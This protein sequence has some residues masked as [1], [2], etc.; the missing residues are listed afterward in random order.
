MFETCCEYQLQ[1]EVIAKEQALEEY[2]R[3]CNQLQNEMKLLVWENKKLNEKLDPKPVCKKEFGQKM[4]T[5]LL[6][7]LENQV[8]CL[9]KDLELVQAARKEADV[10]RCRLKEAAISMKARPVTSPLPQNA[11]K[12]NEKMLQLKEQYSRVR[13]DYKTK[14]SQVAALQVENQNLLLE[15]DEKDKNLKDAEAMI[16]ELQE[17]LATAESDKDR[18]N[19]SKGQACQVTFLE[20]QLREAK[21]EI[22][23]LNVKQQESAYQEEYYRGKY[24]L[25]QQQVE[26]QRRQIDLM[27][28]DNKRITQ[29]VEEEMQRVKCQFQ[30]KLD[31]LKSLPELLRSTQCRLQ[32]AFQKQKQ[33]EEKVCELTMQLEEANNKKNEAEQKLDRFWSQHDEMI[34]QFDSLKAKVE[35]WE[36]KCKDLQDLNNKQNNDMKRLE[37]LAAQ[38]KRCSEEKSLEIMQLN[39]QL[40]NMREES[41]RQIARTKERYETVRRSYQTQVE[42]LERQ[43]AQSR[44][45]AHAAQAERD[46]VS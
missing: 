38:S 33:T 40:E 11:D 23:E 6:S 15:I 27:D 26:E 44:A 42:E 21:D 24:L 2:K 30:D 20:Q 25:A 29:Q 36:K 12:N 39:N 14:V 43:L 17:K 8:K 37:E 34:N 46:E 28:A 18:T 5:N 7:R 19:G 16:K 10:E 35:A 45:T 22:E 41:A 4:E 32:E 3:K 31:E 1:E 13:E 9:Q